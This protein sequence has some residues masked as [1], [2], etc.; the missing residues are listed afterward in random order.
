MLTKQKDLLLERIGDF[1][2]SNRMLRKML[3]DRHEEEADSARL[4]EQR[5]LLLKKLS[6]TEDNL[7]VFYLFIYSY[8]YRLHPRLSTALLVDPV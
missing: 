4:A 5:D 6:E 2:A 1:E 3:R 7:Q 8:L